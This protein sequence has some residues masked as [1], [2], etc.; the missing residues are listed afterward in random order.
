M[1]KL[2]LSVFLD[3]TTCDPRYSI[4]IHLIFRASLYCQNE[5]SVRRRNQ[6][7][8]PPHIALLRRTSYLVQ[9]EEAA[10]EPRETL[11]SA[12]LHLRCR[13]S[14]VVRHIDMSAWC[15]LALP[16]RNDGVKKLN[17]FNW[18]DGR[19]RISCLI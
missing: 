12:A 11:S 9:A 18:R 16:N 19:F 5:P 6:S 3:I 8:A 15:L 17:A 1:A 7:D 14:A 10:R 13:P 2:V 4:R